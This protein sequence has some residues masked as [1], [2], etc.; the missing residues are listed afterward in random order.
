MKIIWPHEALCDLTK[1]EV[2][3]GGRPLYS[4]DNHLSPFGN[5]AIASIFKPAFE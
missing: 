2:Q 5:R 3:R 1:C 4:D